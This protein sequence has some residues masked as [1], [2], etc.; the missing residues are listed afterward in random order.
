MTAKCFR[1]LS[2]TYSSHRIWGFINR[3]KR[4]I[5][6]VPFRGPILLI[7]NE[8]TS[9]VNHEFPS[10]FGDLFFSSKKTLDN[11]QVT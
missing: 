6:S 4:A 10:P 2:G 3:W 9:I 11:K 8:A 5:V 1:P 7:Y